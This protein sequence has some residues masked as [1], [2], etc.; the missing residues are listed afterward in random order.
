MDVYPALKTAQEGW[1]AYSVNPMLDYAPLRN[2]P[3]LPVVKELSFGNPY[4]AGWEPMAQFNTTYSFTVTKHDGSLSVR[5]N[6]TFVSTEAVSELG[7]TP[8]RPRVSLP[9][10]FQVDGVAAGISRVLETATPL[11]TWGAPV[12]GTAT[13]YVLQIT[14]YSTDTSTRSPMWPASTWGLMSGAC[15]CHRD[16][17]L[18]GTTTCCGSRRSTCR[19]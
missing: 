2:S 12:L 13:G 6:E 19:G 14:R 15:A 7:A 5:T 10:S 8:V 3:Q 9:R 17:S 18:R 11:V 16:C 4:P 1:F